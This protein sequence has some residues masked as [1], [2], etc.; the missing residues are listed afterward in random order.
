VEQPVYDEEL[1]QQLSESEQKPSTNVEQPVSDA[2][3]EY[4]IQFF[5]SER[6]SSLVAPSQE[7][8][9]NVEEPVRQPTVVEK[10]P[11]T[12]GSSKEQPSESEPT[13]EPVCEAQGR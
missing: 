11:S 7:S 8:S 6:R 5:E 13:Q 2:E 3:L 4:L 12:S 1:E 9:A 10:Q